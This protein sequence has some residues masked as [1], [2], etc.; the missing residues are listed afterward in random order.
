MADYSM[1]TEL[2]DLPNAKVVHHQ[3]VV[4]PLNW[5]FALPQFWCCENGLMRG[6]LRPIAPK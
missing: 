6:L 1:L 4:A 3:F 2:L 5:L